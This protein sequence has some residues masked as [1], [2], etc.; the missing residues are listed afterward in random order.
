MAHQEGAPTYGNLEHILPPGYKRLVSAWLE[1][2]APSLDYG[3]F[4]VGD[5]PAEARLLGKSKVHNPK[6]LES[7]DRI[8]EGSKQHWK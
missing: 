6:L 8:L 3:G 1:E 2:D 7:Q 4:V 5:N